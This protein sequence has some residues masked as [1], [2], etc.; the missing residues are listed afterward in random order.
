MAPQHTF[1]ISG[2]LNEQ[3]SQNSVSLM[4]TIVLE[5]VTFEVR[6]QQK[7]ARDRKRYQAVSG[8]SAAGEVLKG[9]I[10]TFVLT[11][12]DKTA[13]RPCF[14]GKLNR[15]SKVYHIAGWYNSTPDGEV[16]RVGENKRKATP[17]SDE[18]ACP[19]TAQMGA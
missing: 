13:K 11:D 8:R 1:V 3:T 6:T 17:A 12:A 9:A 10:F 19:P 18:R 15:G 5:G 14:K 4:G 16:I 2:T 7:V